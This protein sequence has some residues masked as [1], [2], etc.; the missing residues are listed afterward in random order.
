MCAWMR[1]VG[2]GI[3]GGVRRGYRDGGLRMSVVSDPLRRGN[4]GDNTPAI[5][6]Y[7]LFPGD[8]FRVLF[9]PKGGGCENASRLAMLSPGEGRD[10][11]ARFV[12]ETVRMAGGRPCPPIIAGVGIGGDFERC[13]IIAKRSLFR[14]IG[15]R[16]P[17][18]YYA[19]LERELLGGL[20]ALGV[21]PMGLGGRTTALDVFVEAEPCHIASLPVAVNIQ[22]HSAR[23]GE[24]Y[25]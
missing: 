10:G 11:V 24:I 21:G 17:D 23:H 15:A 12:I 3:T 8:A 20:N 4:T 6:H 14:K 16:N 13:A 1:G 9:C 7:R 5:I 25:L 22:C 19:E 18:P 2:A